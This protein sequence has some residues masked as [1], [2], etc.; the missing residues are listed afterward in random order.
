MNS[1]LIDIGANLTH[2]SFS[3]DLESVLNSASEKNIKRLI[4]TGADLQSSE[5]ALELVRAYPGQLFSTA[6]IHPHHA[7][8]TNPYVL[9]KLRALLNREEVKSSR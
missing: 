6:G 9:S 1:E 5:A 3:E 4:V 2:E 7:E 8:D